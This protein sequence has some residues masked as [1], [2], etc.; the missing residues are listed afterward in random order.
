MIRGVVSDYPAWLRERHR[1]LSEAG[2][3]VTFRPHPVMVR[4][5]QAS[6]Y[7][8]L[9]R[10]STNPVLRDDLSQNDLV[11]AL[12]SN[13]LVE[14]YLA[15][16]EVQPW[17]HGTMLGPLVKEYGSVVPWEHREQWL[18]HLAWTQWTNEELEDGSWLKHHAPIM[19]RLVET[20]TA[21]PW[22]ERV[23]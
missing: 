5:G 10:L 6:E 15:G 11:V 18:N 21:Y 13:G 9:G 17:N 8:N 7:G 20:G 4:R 16:V 3:R 12:S 22:H 19:H 14:G 1:A 2:Y 23:I